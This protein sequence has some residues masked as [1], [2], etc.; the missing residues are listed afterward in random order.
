MKKQI[1]TLLFFVPGL[2]SLLILVWDYP[3][4]ILPMFYV[5]S[6]ICAFIGC[7]KYIAE[8]TYSTWNYDD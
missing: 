2:I 1:K 7:I 8:S 3:S 5:F 4:I 6:G